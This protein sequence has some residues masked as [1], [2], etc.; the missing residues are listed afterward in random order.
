[1]MPKGRA[2]VTEM[3]VSPSGALLA[4]DLWNA[5]ETS[6]ASAALGLALPG[7]GRAETG[8]MGTAMR[9]GPRRWWLD[10]NGFSAATLSAALQG[11][12]IVTPVEGGW[13]RVQLAGA[14]WRELVMESGLIDAEHPAFG[15]GAVTISL[16]CHARC[17]IHVPGPNRCEVFV[18][19]SYSDHCLSQWREMGWQQ[20]AA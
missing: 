18:P 3:M 1:M 6:V 14:G 2:T 13:T 19:A 16:L 15:P 20:V 10:G 8:L 9:L 5:D 12:G 7:P 17:V 4:L 11:T